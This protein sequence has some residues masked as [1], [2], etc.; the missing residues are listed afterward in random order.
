MNF[1]E[2]VIEIH[3]FSFKKNALQNVVREMAANFVSAW[4]VS[5]SASPFIPHSPFHTPSPTPTITLS[6]HPSLS[7]SL[8]LPIKQFACGCPY[9]IKRRANRKWMTKT[10]ILKTPNKYIAHY[11][12]MYIQM[13]NNK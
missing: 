9:M 1:S 4:I 5:V 2:I 7:P 3:T 10:N 11:K 8:S 12:H 6:P 13:N